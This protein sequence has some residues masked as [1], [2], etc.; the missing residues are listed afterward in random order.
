VKIYEVQQ[1]LSGSWTRVCLLETK[2]AAQK[3]V[4][5]INTK[6]EIYPVRITEREV[7][8]LE[9]LEDDV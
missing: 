6:V 9:N 5:S 3:Y 2:E 7:L 4:E 1:K 8:S